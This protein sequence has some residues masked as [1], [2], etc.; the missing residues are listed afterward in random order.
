[1]LT[2]K[3]RRILALG[4]AVGNKAPA[5]YYLSAELR[6][7]ADGIMRYEQ[8]LPNVRTWFGG[9]E[10]R[11]GDRLDLRKGYYSYLA[12]IRVPSIPEGGLFFSPMFRLSTQ[13]KEERERWFT[14]ARRNREYL[15][16][17]IETAPDS[18]EA[19]RARKVLQAL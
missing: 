11:H 15:D 6:V 14:F 16:R 3:H 10:I 4:D 18:P 17:V 19:A 8:T 12:E 5:V 9:R 7:T 1:M 13:V 2:G